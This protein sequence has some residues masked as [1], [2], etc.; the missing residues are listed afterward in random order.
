MH[1]I[2]TLPPPTLTPSFSFPPTFPTL[3]PF[4]PLIPL[5]Y[6]PPPHSPPLSSPP[7]FP[8]S[9][10]YPRRSFLIPTLKESS[11]YESISPRNQEIE[12]SVKSIDSMVENPNYSV[13]FTLSYQ[14]LDTTSEEPSTPTI[15]VSP[16]MRVST[17]NMMENECYRT[18]HQ[19]N[20]ETLES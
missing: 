9:S 4:P 14:P 16:Q 6:F 3:H 13:P 15:S 17:I 20:T 18:P 8:S 19:N 12:Q 10:T 11:L 2:F 1:P 7:L 5:L